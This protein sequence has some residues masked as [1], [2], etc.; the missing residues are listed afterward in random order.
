MLVCTSLT[1]ALM[2]VALIVQALARG[3][4]IVASS[5]DKCMK[6]P[7]NMIIAEPST[8]ANYFHLLR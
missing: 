8:P 2:S 3:S 6:E 4:P 5:K 7:V 1:I